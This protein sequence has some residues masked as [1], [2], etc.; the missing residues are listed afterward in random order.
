[1]RALIVFFIFN[2]SILSSQ[3][4]RLVIPEGHSKIVNTI[5]LDKS[6]EKILS[7]GSDNKAMLWDIRSGKLLT[8]LKGHKD[9][10][11]DAS[12]SNCG[13][14]II[15]NSIDGSIRIWDSKNGNIIKVLH[16]ENFV[17]NKAFIS[18]KGN[19]A[20]GVSYNN[21]IVWDI[22]SGFK[23]GKPYSHNSEILSV[24]LSKD[25]KYITSTSN[26]DSSIF[27]RDLKTG[28][29]V[30]QLFDSNGIKYIAF[31]NDNRFIATV[32]GIFTVRIWDSDG[33]KE[34]H[35][36]ECHKKDI[37]DVIFSADSKL[38]ILTSDD[39]SC[40]TWDLENGKLTAVLGK[41]ENGLGMKTAVL[42][43]DKNIVYSIGKNFE[44]FI[45]IWDIS[46]KKRISILSG[47]NDLVNTIILDN[48]G[49][50][51]ISASNDNKILVWNTKNRIVTS[52]SKGQTDQVVKTLTSFDGTTF[53]SVN[54]SNVAKLFELKTGKLIAV[55]KDTIFSS[56]LIIYNPSNNNIFTVTKSGK[57][58]LWNSYSGKIIK[59]YTENENLRIPTSA[60]FSNNGEKLSVLW[61][62]SQI[63][64]FSAKTLLLEKNIYNYEII[65]FLKNSPTGK[66]LVYISGGNTIQCRLLDDFN[67][68][69]IL[70]GH[71]KKINHISYCPESDKVI[72]ASDDST[73]IIWD[74]KSQKFDYVLNEFS[75]E[76]KKAEFSNNGKFIIT[77]SN[78]GIKI[79]DRSSFKLILCIKEFSTA[80][81]HNEDYIITSHLDNSIKIWNLKNGTLHKKLIVNSENIISINFAG[82]NYLLSTDKEHK[83]QVL[84]FNSTKVIYNL[85]LFD[86]NQW[87][88][89]QNDSKYYMCSKNASKLLHYV[90]SELKIIGFEQLD[91]VYNRPDIVLDS[92]GKY[93][94]GADQELLKNYRNS[95]ENR[96]IKLGLD[97]E[98]LGKGEV[99]VPKAEIVNADS[100]N[101][102]N[103]DGKVI[104][105]IAANDQK[106]RLLRYNVYVNEVPVYGSQGIPI[107]SHNSNNFLKIDTINLSVGKNKIQVSVMNEL[108]LENF[109]YPLYVNYEPA[110]KIIV[111]THYIGIGVNEFI[112]NKF[113]LN[114]CV[115]DVKD[116]SKVLGGENCT[117][118][119]FTNEHAIRENV[120]QIKKY[121]LENTK[122]D[123][124]V[125]ISCSSHG[126]LDDSRNF[127]L[128]MHDVDFKNPTQKGLRYEELEDLLDGIPARKKLLL[129]DACNSGENDRT[130]IKDS[131][132]ATENNQ[133]ENQTY[134]IKGVI[135]EEEEE[136]TRK[137]QKINELF[138]NVHNKTGSFVISAAGGR[139][140]ARE[141]IILDGKKIENGA[142]T[143]SVL[144]YLRNNKEQK[145]KLTVNQLK[146]YVEQRVIEL[147][148]GKQNPTSRQETMEVDWHIKY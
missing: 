12:F 29:I 112:D 3:D 61:D 106:Y 135:V 131:K 136:E 58:Q 55:L 43:S 23:I 133:N 93:F 51:L 6:E 9:R 72:S 73:A 113:N 80:S 104:L 27:V 143:H 141:G 7:S 28:K 10:I 31:S 121:L 13:R 126:L 147:T 38:L 36:L 140:H 148:N 144:E 33:F 59:E 86:E 96:I 57:C 83:T 47:H 74:I 100:I 5:S 15:T 64:I 85:F 62:L 19:Y 145:D 84:D 101:Y 63:T 91:P 39:G 77:Y 117:I 35:N 122:I 52:K 54:S 82:E 46:Q 65:T 123:D 11:T 111:K 44:N 137:F 115:N 18:E 125:I 76:V 90:T 26:N 70:N 118:K 50:K 48:K 103:K 110:H 97:K 109:K 139:Q 105:Q 79:F 20:V 2:F 108:G 107:L 124:R 130:D 129:L 60:S 92:I 128:A 21:L 68:E 75:S 34:I 42:S 88:V 138:V 69:I 30:N 22:K 16:D 94:G 45:S 32:S 66:S 114:Y 24:A 119:L 53:I 40:S 132:N 134:A 8:S 14:Y 67:N 146:K 116:L 41:N 17:F 142:F 87:L 98:K 78:D 37:T 1:M 89:K 56:E 71:R 25:E 102:E 120:L 81:T 99:A 127:Y 49:T 95:W 4:I